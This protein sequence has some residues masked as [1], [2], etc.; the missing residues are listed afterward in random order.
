MENAIKLMSELGLT[1]K[2]RLAA[3]KLDDNT[4]INDFLKGPKF[5]T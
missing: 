1:P 3:N 4:K 2:S 5:G